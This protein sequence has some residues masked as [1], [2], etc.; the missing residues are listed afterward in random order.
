MSLSPSELWD[1]VSA[2]SDPADQ[3]L[4]ILKAMPD[5]A[6]GEIYAAI[7]VEL[8]SRGFFEADASD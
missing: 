6:L 8:E 3:F 2:M 5:E 7:E 4:A 1:S